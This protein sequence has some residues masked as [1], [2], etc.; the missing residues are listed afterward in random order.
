[1]R[2]I[3]LGTAAACPDPE[4]NHTGVLLTTGGTNYLFDCGHGITNQMMRANVHPKD[5]DVVF[6]THLHYDHIVDFPYFLLTSW[7]TN[8]ENAPTVYG[9]TGT[10]DFIDHLFEGGA[11]A[12]DIEARLG[13]KNRHWNKHVLRPIVHEYE[14]GEIFD[15]GN[16]KVTAAHVE[17]IPREVSPCFGL[18]M[19]DKAGK[20]V[21][22]SSDTAPCENVEILAK[23]CDLLIHECTFPEAAL[24]FRRTANVGTWAH[25][26]PVQLGEIAA[27]TGCKSLVATHVGSY[28]TT[29]PIVREMMSV[30]MPGEII[31]PDLL[32]D[33]AADIRKSYKGDLRLA[34]DGMRIYL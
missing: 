16:V 18:R 5:V 19:E 13:Y 7:I 26:S 33:V 4:R 28:D 6:L 11:F 17:H 12:K 14:P 2:V 8:R 3:M 29:N 24:E 22:F 21:T 32:D 20:V 10:Q 15:D 30:H 23:D 9:P 1:M 31:G 27:R 25:T 34:A